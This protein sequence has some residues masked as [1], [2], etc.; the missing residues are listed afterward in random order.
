MERIEEKIMKRW[1]EWRKYIADGGTASWPRE[2]F[3]SLIYGYEEEIK[4]L[5][6]ELKYKQKGP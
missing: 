1:D 3:E 6:E 2:E 4:Q 5:R